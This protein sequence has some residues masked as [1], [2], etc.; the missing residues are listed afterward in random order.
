M[1]QGGTTVKCVTGQMLERQG[2]LNAFELGATEKCLF[3]DAFNAVGET[4]ITQTGT[5]VK[6]AVINFFVFLHIGMILFLLYFSPHISKNIF[7]SFSSNIGVLSR[8]IALSIIVLAPC[9]RA[10]AFT[11]LSGR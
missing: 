8:P 2:K 3:A 9:A 7:E 10:F 4:D 11:S 1:I 6:G 5:A